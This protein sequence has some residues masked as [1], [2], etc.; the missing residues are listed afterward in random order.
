[1]ELNA[2]CI[3]RA[4]E[5]QSIRLLSAPLRGDTDDF[6]FLAPANPLD[7]GASCPRFDFSLFSLSQ[8]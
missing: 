1:V 6:P 3:E 7:D 5:G 4:D 8:M 2:K